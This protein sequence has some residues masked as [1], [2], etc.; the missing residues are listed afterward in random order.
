VLCEYYI[1]QLHI[2][3]P[4]KMHIYLKA[5]NQHLVTYILPGV[6]SNNY[7]YQFL[8]LWGHFRTG[9]VL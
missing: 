8:I 9:K 7:Y 4:E 2:L 5:E 6:F 3:S 1:K